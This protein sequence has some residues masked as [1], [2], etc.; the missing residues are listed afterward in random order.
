VHARAFK[1]L[2]DESLEFFLSNETT[3]LT[4]LEMSAGG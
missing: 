3:H 4:L 2:G 1:N